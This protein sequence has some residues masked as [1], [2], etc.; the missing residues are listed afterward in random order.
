M[1][2]ESKLMRRFARLLFLIGLF[3]LAGCRPPVPQTDLHPYPYLDPV[4]PFEFIGEIAVEEQPYLAL[5]DGRRDL[6]VGAQ[7]TSSVLFARFLNEHGYAK[8]R[9][10][11]V[12]RLG[13]LY[14]KDDGSPLSGMSATNVFIVDFPDSN[15]V[16]AGDGYEPRHAEDTCA[17]GV[18]LYG[19][20][21][22]CRWYELQTGHPWRLPTPYEWLGAAGSRAPSL[23]GM[24]G[25]PLEWCEAR[26]QIGQHEKWAVMGGTR[27]MR[28]K[29][30]DRG[31]AYALPTLRGK[32]EQPLSFRLFAEIEPDESVVIGE[33]DTTNETDRST[34][35]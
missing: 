33:A 25:G 26:V 14:R 21:A 19:A 16:R 20:Q 5:K 15:P 1:S 8:S 30:T 32:H 31:I 13:K 10:A 7:E 23:K 18:T 35:P 12:A 6:L 17:R 34:S 4:K 3:L 24:P 9:P 29:M 11:I 22:F 27:H 2:A 28:A